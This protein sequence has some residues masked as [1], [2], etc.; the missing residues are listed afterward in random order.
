[1]QQGHVLGAF[2][3][4]LIDRVVMYH[5]GNGVEGLGELAQDE[6]V[7]TV[8]DLHVHKTTRTPGNNKRKLCEKWNLS[9]LNP[10]VNVRLLLLIYSSSIIPE[11][12][13]LAFDI[14]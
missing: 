7:I 13:I 1:M 9:K 4:E 5:E 14:V 2:D 3:R 11:H 6:L 8:D 12:K 10:K